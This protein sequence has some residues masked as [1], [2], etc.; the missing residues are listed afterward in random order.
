MERTKTEREIIRAGSA[1]E[2]SGHEELMALVWPEVIVYQF[3]GYMRARAKHDASVDQ[4]MRDFTEMLSAQER[5]EI[6]TKSRG[7]LT[8]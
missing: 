4:A 3:F 2:T 5:E 1:G 6:M 7:R 8:P